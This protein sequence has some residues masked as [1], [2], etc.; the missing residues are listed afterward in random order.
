MSLGIFLFENGGHE[1]RKDLMIAGVNN[2]KLFLKGHLLTIFMD[3]FVFCI[4]FSVTGLDEVNY[5]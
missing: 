5:F 3:I 1:P 2:L 4:Q